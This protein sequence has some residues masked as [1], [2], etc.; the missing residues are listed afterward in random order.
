[1]I[2]FDS[3]TKVAAVGNIARNDQEEVVCKLIQL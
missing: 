2:A 1:M 3:K